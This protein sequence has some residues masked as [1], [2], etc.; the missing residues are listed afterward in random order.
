MNHW[1]TF[2]HSSIIFMTMKLRTEESLFF[3]ANYLENWRYQMCYLFYHDYYYMMK[4]L[5]I[6]NIS[7][8]PYCSKH[9]S[10]T[11]LFKST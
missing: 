11:L 10:G 9:I 8:G 1:N 5:S 4:G 3:L 6:N 7:R 2:K